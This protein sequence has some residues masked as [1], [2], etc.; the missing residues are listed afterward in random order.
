MPAKPITHVFVTAAEGR[1]VPIPQNEA[2]APGSEL[3]RVKHG[4]VHRVPYSTFTRKRLASGDLLLVNR[5][6]SEVKEL[7]DASA[8]DPVELDEHGAV[9]QGEVTAQGSVDPAFD[10]SDTHRPRK[11]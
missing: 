11:G 10:L 3:L 5:R 4:A 6:G 2:T 9:A 1:E 7:A 8:P